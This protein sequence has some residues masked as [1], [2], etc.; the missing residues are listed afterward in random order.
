[1]TD[2]RRGNSSSVPL[3]L[4]IDLLPLE[5]GALVER[6]QLE[7]EFYLQPAPVKAARLEQHEQHDDH[8]ADRALHALC[9]TKRRDLI[10]NMPPPRAARPQPPGAPP[11]P[12]R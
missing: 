6:E 10:I 11:H 3:R 2:F 5:G 9:G 7:E 12:P 1:M 8:A 4:H